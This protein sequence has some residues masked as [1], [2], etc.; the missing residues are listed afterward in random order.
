ML[1]IESIVPGKIKNVL[2]P[3]IPADNN[4]VF[5]VRFTSFKNR[6]SSIETE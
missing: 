1:L 2:K 5:F 4:T 3:I 6:N